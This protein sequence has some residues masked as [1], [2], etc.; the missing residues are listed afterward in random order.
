ME[1]LKK[2]LEKLATFEIAATKAEEAW[3]LAPESTELETAFDNAYT[4][5]HRQFNICV[6]MIRDFS[7]GQIDKVTAS[8]MVSNPK[9][10]SRLQD[11]IKRAV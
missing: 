7:L 8:K 10:R 9:Y 3:E 5:E 4:A 2:A 6:E 11:L 1:Q